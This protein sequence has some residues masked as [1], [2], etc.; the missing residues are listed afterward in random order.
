MKFSSSLR[1]EADVLII[2][3]GLAGC[4]AAITAAQTGARVIVAEKGYCGTAG[5][6]ASAGPG[7][8]FIPPDGTLRRD[9]IARRLETAQGLGDADWME[10]IIDRTFR[11]LPT[12]ASH[13]R[14]TQ[15]DNGKVRYHALRGPE[16]LRALRQKALDC[17]V[18]IL[19]HSP[20]LALLRHEDTS[21]AGATGV[22]LKSGHDQWIVRSGAT[23]LATG[24]CAF[25]S[26]LLGS[27]NNTGDGLLMAADAGACFSGME[28]SA[29]FTIVPA[30]TTMA[31]TMIYSFARYYDAAGHELERP[32][33][34]HDNS[35][36]ARALKKGQVFCDLSGVPEDIRRQLPQISPNVPIT[37]QRLGIDPFSQ[38]FPVSLVGEGTIRGVGGIRVMDRHSGCGVP[39]LYV[40]GDV[41]SREPVAGAISGGG[42]V[43][44]AWA[45]SSGCIAAEAAVAY[46]RRQ[47]RS[48]KEPVTLPEYEAIAGGS[49]AVEH[50]VQCEMLSPNKQYFRTASSLKQSSQA[51]EDAWE[52]LSLGDVHQAGARARLRHQELKALTAVARW[53]TASA[54]ARKESRGL[55]YRCDAESVAMP[56]HILSGG[57]AKPWTRSVPAKVP[58]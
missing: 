4:W 29:F 20:A 36:L 50:A 54:L 1:L 53:C 42:A 38:K 49:T 17:G 13:Y 55:H 14:Y 24:G 23:I 9:A 5:V 41:A 52:H 16:Y 15:D 18:T 27:A 7:H 12:I 44:A 21:I 45:L 22:S 47:R 6:A 46:T 26:H 58:S 39:G 32:P 19:D 3:G 30:N 51:L 40:A 11:T 31:R 35:F 34:S 48:L 37:F 43:N 57:L 33:G 8:W 56:A 28:F 10:T 25:R 2:G